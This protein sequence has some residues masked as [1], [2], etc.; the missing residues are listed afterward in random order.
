MPHSKHMHIYGQCKTHTPVKNKEVMT[1]IS[2]EIAPPTLI[3]QG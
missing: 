1:F 2:E 3:T